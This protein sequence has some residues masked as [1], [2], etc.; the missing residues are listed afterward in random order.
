MQGK[1]LFSV[2]GWMALAAVF[3]SSRAGAQPQ[4]GNQLPNPRLLTISPCGGKAGT[5]VEISWT[6]TDVENPEA[7]LSSHPG[8]KATAVTP[9]PPKVDPKV[10]PDPNKPPPPPP[11]I[12]K[13]TVTIPADVPPG[14]Y[15]VRMVNKFG[16]S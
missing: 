10:K 4:L 8:I 3:L 11:P 1:R 14:N 2:A 13:F 5:T 7:F 12:T 15:D 6:G 16:V 9:E